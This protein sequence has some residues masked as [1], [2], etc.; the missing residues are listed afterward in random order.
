MGYHCLNI[1]G[2]WCFGNDLKQCKFFPAIR[3]STV[4]TRANE[5]TEFNSFPPGQN[6]CH[7]TDDIF[8]RI[9]TNQKFCILIKIS[10]KFVPKGPIDN[11]SALYQVMAWRQTDSN[12]T[13]G[14]L[15]LYCVCVCVH[16]HANLPHLRPVFYLYPWRWHLCR[17]HWPLPLP[18]PPLNHSRL[19]LISSSCRATFK[20]RGQCVVTKVMPRSMA[21]AS[22][23]RE[24]ADPWLSWASIAPDPLPLQTPYH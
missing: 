21:L 8:K 7:F 23:P 4:N 11:K 14:V 16:V 3:K 20:V 5:V 15:V 13:M 24:L 18:S 2:L 6:G 12:N 9:F 10:R 19:R 17:N 22:H 1:W